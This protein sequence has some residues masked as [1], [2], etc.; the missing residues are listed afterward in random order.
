MEGSRGVFCEVVVEADQGFSGRFVGYFDSAVLGAVYEFYRSFAFDV[1]I[2]SVVACFFD[3][4]S[5][6]RI[7]H[8]FC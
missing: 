3:F 2:F 6:H 8:F 4:G 7:K 1:G 5:A